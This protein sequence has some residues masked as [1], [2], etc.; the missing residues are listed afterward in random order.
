[1]YITTSS[2]NEKQIHEVA[3]AIN[4]AEETALQKIKKVCN[5]KQEQHNAVEDS[6]V[7]RDNQ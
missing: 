3:K 6:S 4:T 7:V 2:Q 1:M 5:P